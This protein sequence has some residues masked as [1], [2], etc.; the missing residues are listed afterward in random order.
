MKL[1][2][3]RHG[4]S[5]SLA[6]AGV[7]TDAERPLSEKGR[8]D[9]RAMGAYLRNQ[10]VSPQLILTSPLL[11][12]QQTASEV[13][14]ILAPEL[15]AKIL[16]ALQNNARAE[17]LH[18]LVMEKARNHPEILTV[19]HQPQ[20]GEWIAYLTGKFIDLKAGGLAALEQHG[21]KV[22]LLWSKN[23]SDLAIRQ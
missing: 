4:D 3:L 15:K 21:G 23:P 12:A 1:Y 22:R 8:Q 10:G 19:G 5:P 16:D 2:V 18:Q 14:Q 17:V 9:I 7:S 11:R 20:L 6:E 13:S